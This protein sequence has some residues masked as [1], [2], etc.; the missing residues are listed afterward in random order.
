MP[1]KVISQH[2]AVRAVDHES[3]DEMGTSELDISH[4][5]IIETKH[6]KPQINRTTVSKTTK[7]RAPASKG[8]TMKK[9]TTKTKAQREALKDRTN[10]RDTSDTEEVEDFIDEDV[11][12][13]KSKAKKSRPAKENEDDDAP[14]KK[15]PRAQ[16]AKPA[17]VDAEDAATELVPKPSSGV[18]KAATTKRAQSVEPMRIIPE[19]QPMHDISESIEIEHTNMDIDQEPTPEKVSHFVQRARSVSQQRQAPTHAIPARAR[20]TSQQPRPFSRGRSAS[21]AERRVADSESRKAL[22]E[23]TSRY[24]DM[25]LKYQSLCELGQSGA[26]SNFDK[27]KRATDQK[28]RGKTEHQYQISN[29]FVN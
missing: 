7:K 16:K 2:R 1:S 5:S 8:V 27:L 19:T 15:K 26:E 24:E 14:P 22:K 4:D 10:I 21:E 29:T 13:V 6:A 28:A 12:P 23:M 20:S 9:A 11:A 25:Q 3:A 17:A 18:R